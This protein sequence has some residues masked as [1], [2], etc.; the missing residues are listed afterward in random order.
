MATVLVV[1]DEANIL[2]VFA[3]RLK[4]RGHTVLTS[5]SAEEGL[6]RL[7][8]DDVDVLIS[9][10]VLPGKSGMDLLRAAKSLYPKL[11]VIMM[12]AYGSIEMAV[13]AMKQGAYDY[14]T[15][16]IDYNEMFVLVERALTE[17]ELTSPA[18]F[19]VASEHE[20]AGMIGSAPEMQD[21]F[22]TIRRVADSRA[23]VLI[24]GESGTGKE[25]IARALHYTSIRKSAPFIAV[26]CTA[27]PE[28][29]LENELFGHEKGS[30]TGAYRQ[31]KG[32]FELADGGTLFLDEIAGVSLSVQAKLLRVLQ[33]RCFHRIG[34]SEDVHV[35]IRI[36]ASTQKDLEELVR[37]GKFRE[38]LYYRLN[39]ITIKVP[40]LRSRKEDVPLLAKHFLK[41]YADE[42]SKSITLFAPA[43]MRALVNYDWP[44]NVRE[45]ENVVERAVVLCTS[46]RIVPENIRQSIMCASGSDDFVRD[47]A[48]GG[49]DFMKV[50]RSIILRALEANSWN[51]SST[52][53]FLKISRKQLRTKMRHHGLLAEASARGDDAN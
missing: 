36:E 11:P 51:Q 37:Q 42:N 48:S 13:E 1:D 6:K 43:V 41:K 22:N 23:T 12:T 19:E 10:Y 8:T 27:I 5:L 45:L 40:P 26:N 4:Q 32:K 38:D 44:G 17:R 52:A 50:E 16:P 7:R 30:Y 3:A 33:E 25:L 2:K 29:L 9:D 14:L 24:V 15:K 20:F 53:K 46:D 18:G 31:D 35:D 39:V 34:G 47:I 28:T 21:V 49:I